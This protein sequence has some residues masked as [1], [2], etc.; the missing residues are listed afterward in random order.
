MTNISRRSFVM[1]TAGGVLI[2]GSA[3]ADMRE[4]ADEQRTLRA[5]LTSAP[6]SDDENGIYLVE[7]QAQS[8]AWSP[9]AKM[10]RG[11]S[12]LPASITAIPDR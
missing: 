7:Y 9:S 4:H 12:P 1:M 10:L 6:L 11:A 5:I 3:G 2:P 8:G